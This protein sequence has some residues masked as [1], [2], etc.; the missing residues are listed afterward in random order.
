MNNNRQLWSVEREGHGK[1][2]AKQQCYSDRWRRQS[3]AWRSQFR[4]CPQCEKAPS[5]EVHH[6][7][8]PRYDPS[9]ELDPSNCAVCCRAC[10]DAAHFCGLVMKTVADLEGQQGQQHPGV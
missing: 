6:L 2:S 8:P 1:R 5:T 3:R 7:V 4:V 10:H 9:R